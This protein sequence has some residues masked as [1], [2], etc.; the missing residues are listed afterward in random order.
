VTEEG[1]GTAE[2][3]EAFLRGAAPLFVIPGPAGRTDPWRV[4][5]GREG[6]E[7]WAQF[8]YI[9]RPRPAAIPDSYR[10]ELAAYALARH[11]GLDLVPPVVERGINETLGSLQ[12]FV[13]DAVRESEI[14]RRDV[15][16]A[17]PEAHDRALAD[18]RV[19][20]NLVADRCDAE[21]DR[22]ILV[23]RGTGK[24]FAVDFSRAFEPRTGMAPGCDI[25]RC[26]RALY[27]KVRRWDRDAVALLVDAYLDEEEL[28]ALHARADAVL[29][30]IRDIIRQ[31]GESAVLFD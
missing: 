25:A 15:A 11:L 17:D 13:D 14:K 24:V 18:L 26:S 4:R 31:K 20:I 23:Q 2:E 7:R 5:L 3:I 1:P 22:D 19:F 6:V 27:E 30:A 16:L 29:A 12:I 21:R 9:D 10:Y 28:A 8:K